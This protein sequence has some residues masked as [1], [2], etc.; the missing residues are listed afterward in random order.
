MN[1][2]SRKDFIAIH[3]NQWKEVDNSKLIK[4]TVTLHDNELIRHIKGSTYKELYVYTEPSAK[5]TVCS[6]FSR[7][8]RSMVVISQNTSKVQA[9]KDAKFVIDKANEN[10]CFGVLIDN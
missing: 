10:L 8:D 9:I 1:K 2:I 6:L 3:L 7:L 5:L 4:E